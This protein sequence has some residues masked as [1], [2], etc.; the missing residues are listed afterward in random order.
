MAAGSNF[1]AVKGSQ[2]IVDSL[3]L[4]FKPG[5]EELYNKNRSLVEDLLKKHG[6]V[7][8]TVED[9]KLVNIAH[10][11]S[12]RTLEDVNS[13]NELRRRTKINDMIELGAL[14]SPAYQAIYERHPE[15][16]PFFD[17][18][19]KGDAEEA[20]NLRHFSGLASFI[21]ED[22]DP[23]KTLRA[24]T[25]FDAFGEHNYVF[26]PLEAR[27][28]GGPVARA[29]TSY[30]ADEIGDFIKSPW[31]QKMVGNDFGTGTEGGAIPESYRVTSEVKPVA[32]ISSVAEV[33]PKTI[34]PES[35][36]AAKMAGRAGR[37]LELDNARRAVRA[38]R[39]AEIEI[40]QSVAQG[41]GGSTR[42]GIKGIAAALF[43][44]RF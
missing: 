5:N 17:A 41:V 29:V 1:R 19:L 44:G 2:T 16:R 31:F 14:K 40:A 21:D 23:K 11:L 3:D 37:N 6:I 4:D 30:S 26:D 22:I 27:P 32:K 8:N 42:M 13:Y 43:K 7:Q 35:N 34:I 18:V 33:S 25:L 12:N 36:P 10:S 28:V 9:Q 39:N 38:A 24:R 20:Y 15:R